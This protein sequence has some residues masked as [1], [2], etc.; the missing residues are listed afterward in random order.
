MKSSLVT[1]GRSLCVSSFMETDSTHL[2]FI[3]SDIDFKSESIFKMVAAKK[4]VS[5]FHIH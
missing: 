5:Q 2:L 1:Q 4:D 3:D